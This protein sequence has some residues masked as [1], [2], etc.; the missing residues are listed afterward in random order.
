MKKI[1]LI[2]S[3]VLLAL[4]VVAKEERMAGP[5]GWPARTGGWW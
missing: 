1:A 2:F 5:D 3:L 4:P